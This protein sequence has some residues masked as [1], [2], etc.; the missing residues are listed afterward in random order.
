M[1]LWGHPPPATASLRAAKKFIFRPQKLQ[2]GGTPTTSPP[3]VWRGGGDPD[4]LPP[5]FRSRQTLC[6]PFPSDRGHSHGSVGSPAAAAAVLG[7]RGG[8]LSRRL[9]QTCSLTQPTNP[10]GFWWIVC[11]L[12]FTRPSPDLK[13][14]SILSKANRR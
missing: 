2:G 11:S 13:V 12:L 3:A 7:R 14:L 5:S 4:T 9:A 1:A 10:R 6:L 8:L